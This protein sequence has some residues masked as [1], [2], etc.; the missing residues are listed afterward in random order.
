MKRAIS[1]L[2]LML[3]VTLLSLYPLSNNVDG[4][5]V[6]PVSDAETYCASRN[7]LLSDYNNRYAELLASDVNY[8]CSVAVNLRVMAKLAA[9]QMY[10][11]SVLWAKDAVRRIAEY[12]QHQN[13]IIEFLNSNTFRIGM[14]GSH[15]VYLYRLCHI[16]I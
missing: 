10:I 2:S 3:V 7:E 5:S 8:W 16:I 1:I 14:A 4:V 15:I 13:F 11:I 12:I 9:R 6:S